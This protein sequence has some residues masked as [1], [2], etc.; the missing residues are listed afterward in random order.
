MSLEEQF[1]RETNRHAG[2]AFDELTPEERGRYV[3]SVSVLLEN[4]GNKV[5]EAAAVTLGLLY[6]LYKPEIMESR[7]GDDPVRAHAASEAAIARCVAIG[8][9]IEMLTRWEALDAILTSLRQE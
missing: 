1:D 3:E 6:R 9:A 5:V 7:L 2:T 8:E 4:A